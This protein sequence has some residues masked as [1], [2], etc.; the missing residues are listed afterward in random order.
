MFDLAIRRDNMLNK[1]D[2]TIVLNLTIVLYEL[3]AFVWAYQIKSASDNGGMM[4][5]QE[6]N[7]SKQPL[8][9]K[10]PSMPL[11]KP[12]CLLLDNFS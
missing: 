8:R 1:E 9:S 10:H 12:L 7:Y 11:Y 3:L 5:I 2:L 4:S 6:M